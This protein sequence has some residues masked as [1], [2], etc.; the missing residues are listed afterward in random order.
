MIV[1]KSP[2]KCS[3]DELR[4]FLDLVLEG[5]EVTP[6][7]LEA[8]IRK[9]EKLI[10]SIEGDCLIGIAAV[11]KPDQSHKQ[12]LFQ[13]A[14]ARTNSEQFLFEL[15]WIFVLPSSRGA[16]VS[17]TLVEAALVASD[18]KGI[19]ATTRED[20]IP[21]KKVLISHGFLPHGETYPSNSGKNRIGLFLR[22]PPSIS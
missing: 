17:H 15:G 20:N 12:T 3:T 14:R 13:K 2:D 11:K 18:N 10:F 1:S 7:G 22:H 5:G 4:K 16:G 9:A 21:M 8:R 6:V 19:F